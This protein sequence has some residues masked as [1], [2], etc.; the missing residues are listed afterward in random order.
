MLDAEREMR[1]RVRNLSHSVSCTTIG[2][3]TIYPMPMVIFII[4]SFF[5]CFIFV[6]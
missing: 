3:Y 2:I 1:L 5:L 4:I 6:I